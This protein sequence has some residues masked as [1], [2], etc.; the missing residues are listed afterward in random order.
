MEWERQAYNA[1]KNVVYQYASTLSA[2]VF[3]GIKDSYTIPQLLNFYYDKL[4]TI[5][6]SIFSSNYERK[7][8]KNE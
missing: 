2:G 7:G 1:A 6:V 8:G 4:N 3:R 5:Y